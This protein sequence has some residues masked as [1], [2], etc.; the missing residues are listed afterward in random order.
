MPVRYLM[1]LRNVINSF[2]LGGLHNGL[3]QNFG[4]R[5]LSRRCLYERYYQKQNLSEG[6]R[7]TTINRKKA[8]LSRVYKFAL[9]RGY[10]DVNIVR[11]V[12]IDDDTKR[13]DRVLNDDER[14]RL[15][16]ACQESHWDKIYLLVLIAMTTGA[17]KG[18]LI[19]DAVNK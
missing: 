16:N 13:R 5:P 6:E 10:V 17:R 8:V 9:S 2:R 3:P 1:L 14:Q 11:N 18:E 15:I 19:T 7:A 12:V 4:K